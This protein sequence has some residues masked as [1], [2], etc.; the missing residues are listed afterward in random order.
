MTTSMVIIVCVSVAMFVL[1]FVVGRMADGKTDDT[2]K[3]DVERR[4]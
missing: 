2:D 3:K 4:D 1:M